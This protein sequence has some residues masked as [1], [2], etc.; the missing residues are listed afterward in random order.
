MIRCDMKKFFF[1]R[2]AVTSRTD[3]ATRKVLSKFGAYTRTRSRTSIRKRK[4]TSRPGQPPYSH[5]GLLRDNIFF[6]YDP[7]KRSVVVGPEKLRKG[8]GEA[9]RL[10]E[11]GGTTTTRFFDSKRK[12]YGKRRRVRVE[13]RPYMQ[14]A[15]DTELKQLPPKWRDSVK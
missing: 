9:P 8:K 3:K 5:T 6:G 15:F 12:K 1:D 11:H 10:L 7:G 14:P 4:G 13:K 2:K